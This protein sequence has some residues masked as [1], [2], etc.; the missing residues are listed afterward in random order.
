MS[1]TTLTFKNNGDKITYEPL[2]EDTTVHEE[3]ARALADIIIFDRE[4][5]HDVNIQTLL[6]AAEMAQLII[7]V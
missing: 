7:S 5:T 2:I 4:N 6:L 1:K 3:R